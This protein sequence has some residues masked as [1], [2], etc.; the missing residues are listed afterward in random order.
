MIYNSFLSD[1]KIELSENLIPDF[2]H[3]LSLKS[4]YQRAE[5]GSVKVIP[6][7]FFRPSID[8]FHENSFVF[9]IKYYEIK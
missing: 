8:Q 4:H 5:N 1:L 3:K 7:R 6:R 2:F 9:S